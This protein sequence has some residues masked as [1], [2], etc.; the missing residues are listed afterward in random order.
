MERFDLL[1]PVEAVDLARLRDDRHRCAHPS[2]QSA[3]EPY[4]PPA[5]LARTH[6]RNAVVH[7]LARPPLQGTKAWD[8]VWR[9]VTSEYF[10]DSEKD[11]IAAL[12]D[13]LPLTQRVEVERIHRS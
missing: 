8:R 9:A 11:A 3:E 4:E 10:P 2:Q 1:S 13:S 6:L 7:L 5:E 12:G